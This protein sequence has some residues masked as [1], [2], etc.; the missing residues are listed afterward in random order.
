MSGAVSEIYTQDLP[1][2]YYQS[3]VTQINGVTKDDVL[4]AAQKY[5][6]PEHMA[7][8]IVGDRA[9]IEGPIAA[10]KIA[11]IVVLDVNGDPIADASS[12][13]VGNVRVT[14]TCAVHVFVLTCSSRENLVLFERS[15]CC[16]DPCLRN[17]DPI[18]RLRP[19]DGRVDGYARRRQHGPQVLIAQ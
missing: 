3:F 19:D 1:E 9:K 13:A 6:D 17:D 16:E 10:T 14:G 8:V 18:R 2:N 5:L 12:Y 4:R 7:I 11:P 15:Q